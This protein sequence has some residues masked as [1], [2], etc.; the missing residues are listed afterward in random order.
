M[1]WLWQTLYYRRRQ[2]P[3]QGRCT[4]A[5]QIP[6]RGE[7]MWSVCPQPGGT[8]STPARYS[9]VYVPFQMQPVSLRTG[10]KGKLWTSSGENARYNQHPRMMV[11]SNTN[12]LNVSENID[13][14]AC[15]LII[16][17]NTTKISI[18]AASVIGVLQ[19]WTDY[20]STASQPTT[21]WTTRVTPVEQTSQTTKS[22]SIT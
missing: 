1:Y 12:V 20:T 5:S 6:L 8:T 17:G 14:S 15:S 19:C 22:C 7:E 2:R 11:V 13:L 10:D 9:L 21:Q 4:Q 3:P 18:S 16:P